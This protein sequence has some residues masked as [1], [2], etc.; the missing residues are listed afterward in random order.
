MLMVLGT[1]MVPGQPPVLGK[2]CGTVPGPAT[3]SPDLESSVVDPVC[4]RRRS[5]P[6]SY[7]ESGAASRAKTG[8]VA[9][10]ARK[11]VAE[12]LQHPGQYATISA[13]ARAQGYPQTKSAETRLHRELRNMKKMLRHGDMS[14]PAVSPTA[15]PTASGLKRSASVEPP[16]PS[17]STSSGPS[18]DLAT[19]PACAAPPAAATAPAAAIPTT[20]EAGAVPEASTSGSVRGN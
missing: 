12:F 19:S 20:T 8:N 17:N 9:Q 4:Y 5:G 1:L 11:I 18:I 14:S 3:L 6:A 16:A 13:A 15:T 10:L 2:R 7:D